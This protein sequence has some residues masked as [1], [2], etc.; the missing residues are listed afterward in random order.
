[1][2]G[3]GGRGPGGKVIALHGRASPG[4]PALRRRYA[5]SPRSERCYERQMLDHLDDGMREFVA[6]QQMV[7][8]SGRGSRAESDCFFRSGPPGFVRVLEERRIAWPEYRPHA[9]VSGLETPSVGLLFI[10]FFHDLV[11]L[12]VN[13]RA[14]VVEH[15]LMVASHPDLPV[16]PVPGRE[17]RCWVCVQVDDAYLRRAMPVPRLLRLPRD[18]SWGGGVA[19]GGRGTGPRPVP[20]RRPGAA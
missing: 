5:A 6:R 17:P 4:E 15:E 1:M 13:G 7:F 11:E 9:A 19:Q 16:D 18:R 8:L 20:R 12:H 3:S 14:S 2:A 10:D